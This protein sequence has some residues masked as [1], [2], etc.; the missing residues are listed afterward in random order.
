[1]FAERL[2]H[3]IELHWPSITVAHANQWARRQLVHLHRG[4]CALRG[5][6]L[7]LYRAPRRLSVR[8]IDCGWESSGWTI[9]KPRD[10][11]HS[12]DVQRVVQ[13]PAHA[14]RGGRHQPRFG[15]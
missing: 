2:I 14:G 10:G 15:H 6:D 7:V 11:R 9:E 12:D 1:M 13:L 3:D 5:H 4:V 8:C